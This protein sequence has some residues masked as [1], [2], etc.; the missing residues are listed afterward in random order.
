MFELGPST[1]HAP[2]CG[3]S[4]SGLERCIQ[5]FNKGGTGPAKLGQCTDFALWL[6]I[7]LRFTNIWVTK[8]P[9]DAPAN[10][11]DTTF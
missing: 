5:G 1:K 3:A 10:V 7:F 4:R 6:Y 11:V 2:S 8:K 9:S